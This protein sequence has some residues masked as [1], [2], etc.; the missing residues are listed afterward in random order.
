[1]SARTPLSTPRA[2]LAPP[3][4]VDEGR[5][6]LRALGLGAAATLLYL[7]T[8]PAVPNLDGLGYL[9]L[10]PHNFAAGHL[11]FMPAL[12]ALS[13]LLGDG[14]HAGRLYDALLGGTGVVLTY[15]IARRLFHSLSDEEAALGASFAAG[16]LMLSY[17][18][19]SEANDVEA[20]AAAAVALLATVRFAL[21]FSAHP[22]LGRAAATGALLGVAV[23]SHLTH[24][25]LSVFVAAHLYTHA[26]RHRWLPPAVGG[27]SRAARALAAHPDAAFVVR[28]HDLGGAVRWVLTA[29]HGFVAS[30]GPY[31]LADAVYGLAKALVWS[32][33]LY[34][35]DA[36]KL[37]G[38][39]LLGLVPLGAFVVGLYTA[40]RGLG[41]VDVPPLVWW[42]AP[43]ALLG[44]AFFGADPERWIFVL[45]AGWIVAAALVLQLVRPARPALAVLAWVGLFNLATAV[46]PA[47]H[48]QW[49]RQKAEATAALLADGDLVL[50]PGHSWDE[51]VVF[52]GKAK[53][54]PFPIAYYAAR[55]GAAACWA[56]LD[57]EV[58]AARARHGR[59][60]VVRVLD[61][62]DQDPRGFW[63]LGTVG[64]SRTFLKE[65]I[66]RVGKPTA[67]SPLGGLTV[68]RLD[69]S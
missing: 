23:L 50:F 35:A 15:S 41:R 33:Y 34:E 61:D 46:W 58:Q 17:G 56:R 51:Y 53:V 19:W 31:R 39:L 30:G 7:V 22:S 26:R 29:Q 42:S 40:R 27:A 66:A 69:P 44:V 57:R 12:R 4:A 67:L 9:K 45:P 16:G 38:Q 62:G 68:T 21:S 54:E 24:V 5:H 32:P 28:G 60:F 1:L 8:A 36:S 37:V 2:P 65:R 25:L 63:E 13:Q 47:H 6:R 48:D 49:P 20:Y 59:I 52:Y 11:L 10:L 18:Y 14:L 55:D 43:Y 3:R 64:V